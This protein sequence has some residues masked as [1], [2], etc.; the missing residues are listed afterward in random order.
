MDKK[1]YKSFAI[2]AAIVAAFALAV[3]YFGNI[4]GLIKIIIGIAKPLIIGM[5]MAFVINLIMRQL[6]RIYAPRSVKKAVKATRRPVC[7]VIS[8]VI[9]LALIALVLLLVIPAVA[10]A[11]TLLASNVGALYS[12]LEQWILDHRELM[13]TVAEYVKKIDIDWGNVGQQL[14]NFLKGG[15][16]AVFG[17][18][19][20]FITGFFGMVIDVFMAVIF[21]IYLLASKEKLMNQV[22]RLIGAY[23]PKKKTGI[24]N[25]YH[26]AKGRFSAFVVGQFTEAVI[27]G[28]LCA[29][30]MLILR[31][32]YAAVVG[33]LIGFTALIPVAGAYIGGVLGFLLCLTVSPVKALIFLV[34]L[35][36]LQQIES[37]I[38]YPKVVGTSI[39]LP[40]I[41]V[42]TAVIIGG[43]IAG[44]GGMLL[45]VPIMATAYDL[46]RENVNGRET[47]QVAVHIEDNT[48]TELKD[49]GGETDDTDTD[50]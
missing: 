21:A 29:I 24:A 18:T 41:W 34:F 31:L 10:S 15:I 39:G 36:I 12:R 17:S 43:G 6:E 35:V 1:R 42:F 28:S 37:N 47:Q 44:V 3:I 45:G 23:I 7:M 20:T 33:V 2:Y 46:I 38:I 5:V 19:F 26:V 50:S 4:I 8:F 30:G 9:V 13:P 16:G 40:G 25:V 14:V 27:L 49:A 48:E 22:K 32:P 11:I